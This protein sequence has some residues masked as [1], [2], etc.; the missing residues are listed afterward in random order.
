MELVKSI[1]GGSVWVHAIRDWSWIPELPFE[2][3]PYL[4]LLINFHY[5]IDDMFEYSISR[6]L[7]LSNCHYACC[8]GI[9]SEHWHD[10]IDETAVMLEVEYL[11]A[12]EDKYFLMTTWH[13]DVE[14]DEQLN[15]IFEFGLIDDKH[16]EHYLILFLGE[17][18][19]EEKRYI[20]GLKQYA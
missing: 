2:G 18:A 13:D 4:C 19:D 8:A 14:I 12:D 1:N 17:N 20:E 3:K 16:P 5:H 7:I 9:E 6:G 11:A 15:F 10:C